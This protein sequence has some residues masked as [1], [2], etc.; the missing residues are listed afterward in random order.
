MYNILKTDSGSI[1]MSRRKTSTEPSDWE[2]PPP[3][4]CEFNELLFFSFWDISPAGGHRFNYLHNCNQLLFKL[5]QVCLPECCLCCKSSPT[6]SVPAPIPS[7]A[8]NAFEQMYPLGHEGAVVFTIMLSVW[9][10]YI[11]CGA[12][13][14]QSKLLPQQAPVEGKWILAT[15]PHASVSRT[16]K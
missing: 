14:Y 8:E 11:S 12:R 15:K 16:V 5:K 4:G 1:G 13:G 2:P 3:P 9:P 6:Q 7:L 10:Y